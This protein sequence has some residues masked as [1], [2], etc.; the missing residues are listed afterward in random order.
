MPSPRALLGLYRE[1]KN[2]SAL[3]REERGLTH[4]TEE[5]IEVAYDLQ[6]GSYVESMKDPAMAEHKRRY[7]A[8]LAETIR[9]LGEVESVLEAGVGEATTLAGVLSAL[10]APVRAYGFDLSWSRVAV[11]KRWLASHG[12]PCVTLCT[13]SL[14]AI[15]F[16][17][18]SVDVVYTS[19]SIEPNGGQEAPI[20]TELTRV[21][22]EYLVLWEPSYAHASEAG[23]RRM[24]VH[25]YCRALPEQAERLGLEVVEHRPLAESANPLN[26]TAVTVIRTGPSSVPQP[27]VL[28][29]PRFE[30]PLQEVGGML[31]SPEGLVVYPVLGG[32]PC[33]RE[34]NGVLASRYAEMLGG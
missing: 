3:L 21:A 22:R 27:S 12:H 28:A 15:P 30:T 34:D 1:G 26:P 24:E 6:S 25:G 31:F 10:G 7:A 14:R 11:A 8:E 9:G 17:T 13:G 29:C 5:V 20:L 33:L 23:K 19:H 4:N 2:I 18:D 16:A 32:I